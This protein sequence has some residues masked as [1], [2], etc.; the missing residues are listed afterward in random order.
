LATTA[1]VAA[2][3]AASTTGVSSFNSRTGAVTLTLGDVTAVGGAPTASPTFTGVPAGPTAT[4]GTNTTQLATTAFVH[5][6]SLG[7][8]S[9][10]NARTGA[11]TLT[12][13]DITAAGGAPIANPTFTGAPKA[14]T[15][16]LGDNSTNI[17]TTNYVRNQNYISGTSP[18]LT[19]ATLV[20]TTTMGAIVASGGITFNGG[21]ACNGGVDI[22]GALSVHSFVGPAVDGS[23][24]SGS[25]SY[26]WGTVWATNGTI[27]TSDIR[28]KKNIKPVPTCL[29]LVAR[30]HPITFLWRRPEIDQQTHWGFD[31][32]EVNDVMLNAGHEFGGFVNP[33]EG[34]KGLRP[35]ELIAVLWKAVQELREEVDFL[36][37][38]LVPG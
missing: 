30:I 34:P 1:F 38:Q 8:V 28:E 22:A 32:D 19:N 29:E 33:P 7:A 23:V 5:A 36:R 11:V 25:A 17:A 10:F 2:A 31:A 35:Q 12:I 9:S 37:N 27:S 24:D 16:A 15:P 4:A 18:T 26:R 3:V 13:G 21:L 20:G 14:P 6:A